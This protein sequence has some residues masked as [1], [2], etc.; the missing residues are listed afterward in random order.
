[1]GYIGN[2]PAEK[3]QTLQKQSFTTSATT[4]YTL[5]Y[6]VTN[7]Q[8]IALFINNVR[9]NPNSSYT[10]S[11]TA[12]TLSSATSSSDVMYAVF[13]GKSV[14]TIAPATGSVTNDMLSGSIATSK[15]ADGSTF[16]QTNTP[17]FFATKSATQNISNNAYTKVEINTEVFDTDSVYDNSS[18]YRFTVP[19][20][21]AGKY[22]LFAQVTL[23]HTN[24]WREGLVAFYKNGNQDST[25]RGYKYFGSGNNQAEDFAVNIS[26]A[27]DLSVGDYIEVYGYIN[28][29]ASTQARFISNGTNFGGY[30]IIGA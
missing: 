29:G 30:K 7:P 15:L 26:G 1:M 25:T 21:K 5:S 12:L 13:L 24:K 10:V 9:Q 20:G 2:T 23:S 8:E 19:S 22:F 14:G 27:Y 3:Y 11:N 4:S 18:N 16:G 6:S 17:S 28:G